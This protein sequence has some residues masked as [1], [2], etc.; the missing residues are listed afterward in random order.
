MNKS[1]TIFLDI[2]NG[3]SVLVGQPTISRWKTSERPKK[4]RKG[5]IGFN[6]ETNTI[7]YW[8]GKNWYQAQ[9]DEA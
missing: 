9:M 7:E 4:A 5:S 8:D 2:G 1:Q 6:T 3:L